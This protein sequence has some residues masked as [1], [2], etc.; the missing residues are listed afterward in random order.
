MTVVG[1]ARYS[2]DVN[3]VYGFVQRVQAVDEARIDDEG[4][5]P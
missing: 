2:A 3:C 5:S 1:R 4:A